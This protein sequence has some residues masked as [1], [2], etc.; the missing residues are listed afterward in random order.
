MVVT[1]LVYILLL[2]S[3]TF[4]LWFGNIRN[5]NYSVVVNNSSE[6]IFKWNLFYSI[7]LIF[8]VF[9]SGFRYEVGTDWFEYKKYYELLMRNPYLQYQDQ[10]MEFGYFK[11]NKILG[12]LNFNYT[13]LFTLVAIISWGFYFKSFTKF[14]Y[15]LPIS[16]FFIFCDEYFFWSL[17][18]VRQFMA[19][20]IFLYSLRYN[21]KGDFIKYLT[22]ILIASIFHKSVLILIIVYFLPIRVNYNKT[23]WLLLF[24]ISFVLQQ[25][26]VLVNQLRALVRF[27][28][29]SIPLF[30]GYLHYLDSSYFHVQEISTTGLGVLYRQL[31]ALVVII[32]SDKVLEKYP[33]ARIYFIL[34][35]LGTI[36]SNLF[37][38]FQVIGRINQY[39][40]INRAF[41][42]SLTL[43][44]LWKD[45]G[46]YVTFSLISSTYFIIFI[47][48]IKA[49]SNLCAPYT[50]SF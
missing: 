7:S 6:I 50:F 34:F 42:L 47:N 4:F 48:V 18:G 31:I 2:F 44:Y 30:S 33:G 19:I 41:V 35:M 27:L 21:K 39:L 43:Y 26:E 28:G 11:L 3:S 37:L 17:N 15:L 49:S 14:Y 32:Y 29:E 10:R 9:I 25:N 40:L 12:S 1:Y 5:Y 20:T 23:I 46:D 24:I 22:Y 16:I 8:I 38:T 13:A 45:R 36:L